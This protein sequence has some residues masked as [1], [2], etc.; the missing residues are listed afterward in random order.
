MTYNPF[1]II[2]LITGIVSIIISF[3][4]G[5]KI[6]LKFL[7]FKRI[8]FLLVGITGILITEPIL[9]IVISILSVFFGSGLPLGISNIIS[10]SC[11]PIGF[12]T[13]LFAITELMYK[14][15]QKVILILAV[16]YGILFEFILLANPEFTIEFNYIMILILIIMALL[17]VLITGLL[18]ARENLISDEP[19]IQLKGKLLVYAFVS[20]FIFG[21]ITT[22]IGLSE[23]ILTCLYIYFMTASFAFYGGFVLP[24][25]MKQFLLRN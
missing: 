15:N 5:T 8:E 3:Y 16:I 9:G 19:E 10:F 17:T 25:W 21:V 6:A 11:Q 12:F 13:W 23:L 24:D 20:Y 2:Q 18:F 14:K 22:V 1:L 4:V 7:E